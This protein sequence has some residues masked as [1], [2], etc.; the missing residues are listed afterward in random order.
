MRDRSRFRLLVS[1]LFV[2]VVA[3]ARPPATRAD[4]L[5][6]AQGYDLLSTASGTSFPG[7]GDLVGVRLG[8]Y[9]FGGGPVNV[10]TTDTIIHRTADASVS[11]VGQTA[12]NVP[13]TVAALQMETAAPVNF[14][15]VG[16]DNYFITLQSVHG[17]P[18][19]TGTANITFL[20]TG[21]GYFT[22]T[23]DVAFDIRKGS[24]NGLI[25]ASET[26]PLTNTNGVYWEHDPPPLGAVLISRINHLLDGRNTN[27]DFW[28]VAP[29]PPGIIP[30]APP[31]GGPGGFGAFATFADDELQRHVVRNA[32]MSPEPSTCLLVLQGG[33]AVTAFV[34]WRR[35]RV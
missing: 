17:G 23:F 30:N 3:L 15:G 2:G 24:L 32:T 26:L 34:G 9:D 8:T 4:L 22:S 7:L 14:N 33:L 12:M 11:A 28:P 6:V 13:F 21:G 16:M 29:V 35:R 18:A 1:L 27:E 31:G 19:S 5:T 10:G 25:V 20:S